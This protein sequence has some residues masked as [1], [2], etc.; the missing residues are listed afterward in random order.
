M[1]GRAVIPF[2]LPE[3]LPVVELSWPTRVVLG[4]GALGRLP[5]HLAALGVRRPLLVTDAGVVKAGIATR[6]HAFIEAAGMRA[7]RFE[8]VQPNPTDRD[9][10]EGLAAFRRGA[11]DGLVAVG[12]GSSIDVAKLVQ[13]LTTHEPPLSRYDDAAGGDRFVRGDLPPLVAIPT[14]AGTGSE[15]G[16]SGVVTLP[17]T[18]R[19]TVIFSPHLMPRVAICDPRLT[20]DLP[21]Q[22]TAATGMDAFTHG[23]EA[24]VA[25]GFHPLADAVAL[26]AVR[27]AARS[28]PVAV[29]SPADLHAR[30]DMMVAA[31]EGAMAFQKG[32]GAAHA[33]AHALGAVSGVHHGLANAVVLPAVVAFVRP[34]A[35]P[36]LARLAL[37]MGADP[38]EGEGALA[39]GAAA[40]VRALAAGVGIPARLRE[41]GVREVDLPQIAAKALEDASHRASPR[42]CSGAD[43]L[44]LATEAY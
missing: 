34:A 7:E 33:L 36:R 2:D 37:A 20:V 17:D 23:L 1:S 30:T 5:A 22:I 44:A 42:P 13:L 21:A 12:G 31:M 9:A 32:L 43:L 35:G 10:F 8:D 29:A 38:A 6:V 15:V 19:K 3:D 39:D 16:R 40:R 24:Y 27:R 25:A 41:V 28:L 14:T 11:C 18:G 26:D 4:P